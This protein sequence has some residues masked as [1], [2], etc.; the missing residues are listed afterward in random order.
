[1]L[2]LFFCSVRYSRTFSDRAWFRQDVPGRNAELTCMP[3]CTP[4]QSKTSYRSWTAC[5]GAGAAQSSVSSQTPCPAS[6][7]L[8]CVYAARGAPISDCSPPRVRARCVLSLVPCACAS[9]ADHPLVLGAQLLGQELRRHGQIP[10]AIRRHVL[11]S[12][13]HAN[14]GPDH[15]G[16]THSCVKAHGWRMQT[17]TL[18]RTNN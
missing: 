15:P 5:G 6:G 1:M 13:H 8:E 2:P 16:S 10:G 17:C 9:N 14:V 12:Q 11:R 3:G 18:M 4:A 7:T